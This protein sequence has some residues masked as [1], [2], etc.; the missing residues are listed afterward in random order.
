M[1][2]KNNLKILDV[3]CI[4][5]MPPL[6]YTISLVIIG[7]ANDI[8][9]GFNLQNNNLKLYIVSVFKGIYSSVQWLIIS[10]FIL[11]IGGFLSF[12]VFRLLKN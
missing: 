4:F 6:I 12:I 2:I 9:Y 11:S 10:M 3:L 1:G 8:V 5:I 7:I